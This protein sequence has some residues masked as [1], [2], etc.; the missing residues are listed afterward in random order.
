[1]QSQLLQHAPLNDDEQSDELTPGHIEIPPTHFWEVMLPALK[2][3]SATKLL[4][5]RYITQLGQPATW[6]DASSFG[7]AVMTGA[8]LPWRAVQID[9]MTY[10]ICLRNVATVVIDA[11]ATE[12]NAA[13][14]WTATQLGSY[15]AKRIETRSCLTGPL[16]MR[17][18]RER[19]PLP[20]ATVLV[21]A[22]HFYLIVP[23]TIDQLEVAN[24]AVIAMRRVMRDPDWGFQVI[25]TS[26]G[27]QLRDAQASR[28]KLTSINIILV[29]TTVST[30]HLRVKQTNAKA[31]LMTLVDVCTIFD[32]IDSVDELTRFWSYVDGLGQYGSSPL[33]D[34]GDLFGSFRDTHAQIIEGALTPN[35]LALDPHWGA[36]WRYKQLKDF[37]SQAPLVFPDE[38]SAWKIQET[39]SVSSL[40]SVIARN[41]PKFAWSAVI[42]TTTLN[43][44]L[45][46]DDVGLEPQDGS[47]LELFI[48]C[49]ADSIAERNSIIEPFL[50]LPM[51]RINFHCFSEDYLLASGEDKQIQQALAMP[52]ITGWEEMAS[53]DSDSYQA[54]VIVNLAKLAQELENA[55]DATFE[56]AC[57][58]VVVEHLFEILDNPMPS[59]LREAI[60]NTAVRS[61]RFTLGRM[62][63]MVDVPDYTQP[64]VPTFEDYKVARRDLAILLK[65]QDI[66]PGTY[67]LEVAKAL[68]NRA[69]ES[70]RDEVHKRICEMDRESLLRYCTNQ[71]D[72]LTASYNRDEIR[73]KQS[74]RHEVDY[75]RE[76]S[77]SEAHE[78]FIRD[79][80]NYRY[81]L[82]CSVVITSA[83][84]S[85]ARS[86]AV[87]SILAMV[88][89]LLVLYSA[90]DVLHNDID[91][92]GLRI[93]DQYV[94]EVF[95]SEKRKHEEDV[96]GREMAAL[97][98][99]V[100]VIEED[101]VSTAMS[102]EAYFALLD[103]AF[104]K[105]LEF[106]YTHML[107]VF[108]TLMLWVSVGGA[109]EL[110]CEYASEKQS[111]AER[112]VTTYPELP[113]DA[114][115]AVIEFLILKP[116]QAWH[117]IGKEDVPDDVPVWEHF[118]RVSRHAI[119][120]LIELT[121]GRVLWGAAVVER[122]SRIWRGAISG[123]YLP[124]DYPWPS[125]K[126]VV[127]QLKKE[128]EDDLEV[129]AHEICARV[130]P[131][132]IKGMDF[133][134]R[135]PNQD[136]PEVGDFDVLA[137][138]SEKNLWLTVE[139]K[140]NQPAF[141]LKDTRR[142]RDKIFVGGREKSQLQ[143][144]EQR[145]EFFIQNTD[146]LR[147]LLG[148]PLPED[149]PMTLL[150]LYVSKDMHFWLRFPPYEVPTHFVQIDTLDTW[151]RSNVL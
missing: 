85:P 25:G 72:S 36:S 104:D 137:Y 59:E 105:D 134:S 96:F 11:W 34:L 30:G 66:E 69:R 27:F 62:Q 106:T 64:Q 61:P 18:R 9:G 29:I 124:A 91:V 128:L 58:L 148:W 40:S 21:G 73:I 123:G 76:H 122:A 126:K 144:I 145:R 3:L 24:K 37:W 74:L 71:Y 7:E 39:K 99:G 135:F 139:C 55:E 41:I 101:K 57:A 147:S 68:I 79:S 53:M 78:K 149:K 12:T 65:E 110:A 95:F 14:S 140:Y 114:A 113:L 133:K 89:W 127:G 16:V 1:M 111:I 132:A 46:V 32:S 107:Q 26:D 98:L 117:L 97:R 88:D 130:M 70:Y 90:S 31:R 116:D 100:D 13:S 38:E 19:V 146:T 75:D 81:L 47:M 115:L 108:S 94:P 52:L 5:N 35:F 129:R 60:L 42:G 45:S 49:A 86:E 22:S 80:K 28:P 10:A 109:Q 67:E 17:S 15:L 125:I 141:C 8:V 93:D 77:M 102:T 63:R 83:K 103:E 23:V 6:F 51:R 119:R 44:I 48:H 150:E 33:S 43:F 84:T 20:I 131:Y 112:A 138:R 4:R 82:E 56:A 50:Q 121:D 54:R 151:L 143:K 92:G 87:L 136:F 2:N 142:L 118:K 120:P